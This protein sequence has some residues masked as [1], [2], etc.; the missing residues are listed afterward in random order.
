MNNLSC[1][2]ALALLKEGNQHFV[3][4]KLTSYKDCLMSARNR[5]ATGQKPFAIILSCADSRVVPELAFDVG[6]GELFVIRVAGNV[7]NK[8]TVASI[9]YA[10]AN[11]GVNLIVVMGH[12][13]CGAITAAMKGKDLGTNLNYLMSYIE[14]AVKASDNNADINTVVKKNALLT[15]ESLAGK[16]DIIKSVMNERDLRVYSAFY[17]LSSGLVD[18]DDVCD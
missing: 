4:N 14:P 5:S 17:N 16:S 10:V 11:L 1:T 8:H 13:S 6:I 12:E 2:E 7:A 15:A 3:N 18:F 9:E